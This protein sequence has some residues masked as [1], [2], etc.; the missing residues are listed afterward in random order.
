MIIEETGEKRV[1]T[2]CLNFGV[3]LCKQIQ[4]QIAARG[5]KNWEYIFVGF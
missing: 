5:R 1:R 2:N 3:S 4:K